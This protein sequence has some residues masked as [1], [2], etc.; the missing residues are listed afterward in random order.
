MEGRMK[1]EAVAAGV[2]ALE[3]TEG[4]PEGDGR[5]LKAMDPEVLDRPVRRRFTA[6]YKLRILR[7]A[8]RCTEPGQIGALLRR[9]GLYSSN[10]TAWRRQRERGILEALAPSKRGKKARPVNPL[11]GRIRELERE[12]ERLRRRLEKAEVIIEF[13]KKLSELLGIPLEE[14][15]GDS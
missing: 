1:K 9:E 12:N 5:A 11:E 4:K 10:L 7:E 13:Q 14:P 8:D 2:S 3:S 15:E 6:E